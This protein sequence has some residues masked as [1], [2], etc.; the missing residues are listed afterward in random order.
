VEPF[1]IAVSDAE[2]RDLRDRLARTRFA[3]AN[4]FEPWEDGASVEF[5]RALVEHWRNGF[6]W[7]SQETALNRFDHF[8]GEID[9]TM[10]HCIHQRG[11]GPRPLPLLL[12]HGYPD[13]VWRF[14]KLIPLLTDPAAHGGEATD[15]FD[16]VA[17]SLPGY[18][19]SEPRPNRGGLFGFGDLFAKLMAKLG[20]DRYGAHGGDWGSSVVE[21]LAR[22]HAARLIGIHLTDVPF[23]HAFNKPKDLSHEE[24][25]FLEA[26]QKWQMEQGAYAMIQGSR[27]ATPASA[28]ADSPAGLAAWLVEKFYEWSDCNGDIESRFTKDELLTNVMIYWTTGT[29]GSSFLPYRDFM[30]AG[31]ARWMKE[32]V[33]GW[34][35]SD[36]TPA[37]F[38]LF[39]KDIATPP[40]QWAERFFNVQRWSKMT[41]GGHFAAFEE[42]QLLAADIRDFFRPLR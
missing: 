22:S 23:W 35:G 6:D 26:N 13:G 8:R 21:Q 39:P 9:G 37:A 16:I 32:A 5:V 27:P 42:P 20:Y 3:R 1:Q 38:A 17:P 24:Q 25:E 7:R 31:P 2:L 10:L 33:K 11:V 36:A 34:V 15:A 4:D 29:I 12:V 30:K 14:R 19:W 18:G 28:L 41:R 40:R